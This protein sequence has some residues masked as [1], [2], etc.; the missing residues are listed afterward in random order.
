MDAAWMWCTEIHA[1]KTPIHAKIKVNFEK[2]LKPSKQ[3]NNQKP[4]LKPQIK[5]K[6]KIETMALF[7]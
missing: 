6:L 7:Y 4:P 1:D 3:A 2:G 5:F